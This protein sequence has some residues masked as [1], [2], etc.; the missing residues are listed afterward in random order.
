MMRTFI[1]A[2]LNSMGIICDEERRQKLDR[3]I[4]VKTQ[5]IETFYRRSEF[6]CKDNGGK[7]THMDVTTTA[8]VQSMEFAAV[9]SPTYPQAALPIPNAITTIETR[10]R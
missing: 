8:K 10:I 2:V 5:H 7:R 3:V 6:L 9:G 1:G 4:L